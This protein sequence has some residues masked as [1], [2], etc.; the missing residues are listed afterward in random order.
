MLKNLMEKEENIQQQM[1][2]IQMITLR[3]NQKEMPEIKT[4]RENANKKLP[5]PSMSNS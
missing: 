1:I 3:K 5:R 2:N 4:A